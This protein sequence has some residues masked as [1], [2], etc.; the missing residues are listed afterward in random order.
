MKLRRS[1]SQSQVGS[2]APKTP[3]STKPVASPAP[4]A[5][6]APKP[7]RPAPS[8][9]PPL[10]PSRALPLTLEALPR[11]SAWAALPPLRQGQIDAMLR[12][13]SRLGM[14]ARLAA[15]ELL[16]QPD[17]DALP[18]AEQASR[19][20]ATLNDVVPFLAIGEVGASRAPTT[21]TQGATTELAG[22]EFPGRTTTA[23]RTEV[24]IGGHTLAVL[25][26]KDGVYTPDTQH[27]LE[28]VLDALARMPPESLAEVKEVRLNPVRNPTDDFWAR[29]YGQADFRTYMNCGAD[30]V[31]T[32]FPQGSKASASNIA[33]TMVHETGHAWSLREWGNDDSAK[34]G[35]WKA[36]A[37]RDGLTPSKYG[38]NAVEEDL[39][40]S[41]VLYLESRGT[42]LHETYRAMYPQRFAI[43][44]RR[45]G[46]AS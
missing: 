33:S 10:A 45:F 27:S 7:S 17:F 38:R 20:S 24:T 6:W 26:P 16:K 2:G 22:Y 44:D 31:V 43:L 28:E 29:T 25:R 9:A 19:L 3:T 11:S 39:A 4:Q 14:R 35:E 42:P 36:A 21:V 32:V 1:E 46:G 30:G 23:L 8:S 5:G 40:E 18:P 12:S 34:W 13:D 41:Q 15:G 37:Q